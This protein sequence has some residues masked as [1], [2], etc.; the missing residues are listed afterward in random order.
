MNK[1]WWMN[2]SKREKKIFWDLVSTT[3]PIPNER[4]LTL[5]HTSLSNLVVWTQKNLF[6]N[7]GHAM[8]LSHD[9]TII[10]ALNWGLMPCIYVPFWRK[11]RDFYLEDS[12]RITSL[13]RRGQFQGNKTR[14][15]PLLK[16]YCPFSRKKN[17]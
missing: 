17:L 8:S 2:L 4:I 13:R 10:S 5:V 1:R 15:L 6:D 12:S 7:H 3:N 14:L 9:V 16:Q 11:T